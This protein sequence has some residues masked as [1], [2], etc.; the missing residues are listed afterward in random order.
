MLFVL[1]WSGVAFNLH[2]EVY[3]P[4]MRTLFAH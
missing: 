1:A 4:V 3:D 2:E